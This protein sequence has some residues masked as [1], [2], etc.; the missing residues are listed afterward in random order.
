MWS[1]S[2]IY[3]FF[4]LLV[5]VITFTRSCLEQG[6]NYILLKRQEVC[7]E[8]TNL[9]PFV[10]TVVCTKFNCLPLLLL[11]LLSFHIIVMSMSHDQWPGLYINN[12]GVMTSNWHLVWEFTLFLV[13]AEERE[14]KGKEEGRGKKKE[15][16]EK[17]F[18]FHVWIKERKE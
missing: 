13:V 10:E 5:H 14:K 4:T 6:G 7:F 16:E 12:Y 2:S 15:S 3:H 17:I 1:H 18:S 8:H 11:S 9:F